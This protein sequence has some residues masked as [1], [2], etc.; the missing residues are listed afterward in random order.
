MGSRS[1]YEPRL[2]QTNLRAAT[3]GWQRA[4]HVRSTEGEEARGLRIKEFT[5]PTLA[6][7]SLQVQERTVERRGK[8]MQ[9]TPRAIQDQPTGT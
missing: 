8:D 5:P 9:V 6:T 1:Y 2:L 7:Q 3:E 4:G